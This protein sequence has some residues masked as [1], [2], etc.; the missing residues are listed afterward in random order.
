M[1]NVEIHFGQAVS[2]HTCTCT[3]LALSEA[4][5]K[6]FTCIG[7]HVCGHYYDTCM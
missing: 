4:K 3:V 7:I 1:V 6:A 2:L 5:L